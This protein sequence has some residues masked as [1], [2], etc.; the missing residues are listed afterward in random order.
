MNSLQNPTNPYYLHSG[1]NPGMVLVTL[2]LDDTNYHTW[3]RGMK[4]ALLSKNKIKFVNGEI[5]ERAKTDVFHDAWERC[6]MMVISWITRTLNAEIA[7]NSI[8][9]DNVVDL[10][11]DLEERFSKEDHF[12]ISDILQEINSS[13]QGERNVFEYF[14]DLKV[15]W[16]ELEFLRP[17]PSCTCET[18][19]SCDVTKIIT[20]YID[21]EHVISFL[22]GLG[23]VYMNVKT[24]ILL[25]DP[26][27]T[28]NC[29]FSLVQQQEC[30]LIRGEELNK[31]KT[32]V[33]NI[34]SQE[35]KFHGSRGGVGWRMQGS[36][37]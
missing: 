12:R 18:R 32:I 5:Q 2:P 33:N 10:W 30:Q 19:C 7:H 15:L 1:E 20:S 34:N 9:I 8:Y 36:E 14:I 37:R 28:I 29:V 25:M 22:K 6:N 3:S 26:L 4:C 35:W 17:I 27:P 13:K 24:Q 23:D 16:E 11:N 21:Y 31:S